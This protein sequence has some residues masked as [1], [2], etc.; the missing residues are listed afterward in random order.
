MLARTGC[1]DSHPSRGGAVR[2]RLLQ[3]IA[4]AA[5][6]VFSGT[7]QA[8]ASIEVVKEHIDIDVND[9]GSYVEVRETAMRPLTSQGVKAVQQ[10]T[11]S[12]T[13]GFQTIEIPS[14]YTL[15][16]DGRKIALGYG[17]FLY[18]AGA[19][20]APGFEDV[21]TITAVFRNVEVGDQVVYTTVFRQ[22]KPWFDHQFAT[23]LVFPRTVVSDDTTVRLTASSDRMKLKIDTLGVEGG[24][25]QTGGSETL[26]TWHHRNAVATDTE[27]RAVN[28]EADEPHISISTF[29]GYD[30]IAKV[31]AQNIK[32][33]AGVTPQ[34][35]ALADQLTQGIKDPREQAR[36]LYDW[37]S[38]H[39]SYVAIVL[40]AG[41]FIPHEADEV[42]Q[43]RFGDCKD[44]V[45][46]LEAL[47]A[48]KGIASSPVL[49][50]ALDEYKLGG[51]SSPSAFDHLITYVPQFSLFLDSTARYAAFGTLPESDS[52]KPVVLVGTGA[53]MHT[54]VLAA[55]DSTIRSEAD[56]KVAADGSADG[57][58][59]IV[60]TGA[61][62][63]E[64]R[65]YI[66]AIP[67]DSE[68]A[69]FRAV[70]GPGASG[71]LDRG[72][73]AKLSPSYAFGAS[74]HLPGFMNI[75]GPG[76]LRLSL[77]YKP[78]YFSVLLAGDLPQSRTRSYACPSTSAE[79]IVT[80]ELPKGTAID[81]VPAPTNLTAEGTTLAIDYQRLAPNKVRETTRLTIEHAEAVCSAQT[82]NHARAGL[83]KM[84]AA[85]ERQVLYR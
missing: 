75:P 33:K 22:S 38:S 77:A 25:V 57:T 73:P 26:W 58:S 81:A 28:D 46:L 44:H 12:F 6:L 53:V 54:P 66:D 32:G 50:N 11:Q 48:A 7:A 85:F 74:Y 36:V 76:A 41:G 30:D 82:Y 70:L 37:V 49:I 31:Y 47:L 60:A 83:A 43:S 2:T 5:P 84:L 16:A 65:A 29:S 8:G 80:V 61:M 15:K 79:A 1:G 14:A 45:M 3:W 72:E 4:L 59:K 35:R 78:Y 13:R 24:A 18:G 68:A 52:G 69:Y 56:I 55:R 21:Q 20:S 39:I 42:L 62:A 67:P 63:T 51:A 71:S 27:S 34:I 23:E 19:T 40:G 9:D 10:L 64:M 17:D